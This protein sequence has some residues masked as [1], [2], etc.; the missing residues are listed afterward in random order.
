LAASG[1]HKGTTM[2]NPAQSFSMLLVEDEGTTLELLAIILL[3][4]FPDAL[5]HTADNGRKGLDLFTAHM[6]DIVITD[7]KLPEMCG[8]YMI[9]KIR[10]LKPDTKFIIITGD[11]GLLAL[12]DST[13]KG[14]KCDHII[15]KPVIFQA[16]FSAIEL[17]LG[18]SM[19]CSP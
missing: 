1:W 9:D 2:S 14:F 11:T 13:K 10:A 17:C 5:L 18:E 3:K 19:S 8:T 12:E 16:L 15:A 7:F 6:P 4:K